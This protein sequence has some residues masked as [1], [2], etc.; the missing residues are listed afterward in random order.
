MSLSTT[1]M[2]FQI[3]SVE[4]FKGGLIS[5]D[6]FLIDTLAPRISCR[7]HHVAFNGGGRNFS[8][9]ADRRLSLRSGFTAGCTCAP[10]TVGERLSEGYF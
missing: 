5:P 9:V 4:N 1:K 2:R 6:R 10:V 7:A 8:L 3:D